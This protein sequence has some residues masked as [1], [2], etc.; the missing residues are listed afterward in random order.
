MANNSISIYQ[1]N[2]LPVYCT[3]CVIINNVPVRIDAS[4]YIP[5]LTVKKKP[6]D[7][8]T[9]LNKIGTVVDSSGTL[10]FNL[11]Q[12]DTSLNSGDYVFDI[13]IESSINIFTILKD[14]F[15]I[16]DGVRY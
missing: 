12:T 4:S 2:T 9:I 10:Y 13:T 6:T 15:T 7:A 8:S 3:A 5:Y 14:K 11:T 16:L 1:K